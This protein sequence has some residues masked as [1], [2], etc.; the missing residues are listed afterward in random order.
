M[1][2]ALSDANDES[3]PTY[4]AIHPV[5]HTPEEEIAL[6]P[7]CWL[8]DYLRRSGQVFYQL[9]MALINSVSGYDKS[10]TKK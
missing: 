4:Q 8:W 6:G 5:M 9:F 2:F 7:A 3:L 1:N 10:K